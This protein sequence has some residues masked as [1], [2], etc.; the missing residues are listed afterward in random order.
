MKTGFEA[1]REVPAW[2][3]LLVVAAIAVLLSLVYKSNAVDV[4]KQALVTETLHKMEKIDNTLNDEVLR[5]RLALSS[6][7]DTLAKQFPRLRKLQSSLNEGPWSIRGQAGAIV[8]RELEAYAE[9]IDN[10]EDLIERF[11]A[12][13]SILR[14]STNF[15]PVGGAQLAAQLEREDNSEL[16]EPVQTLIRDLLEYNVLASNSARSAVEA[17][18]G[19]LQVQTKSFAEP[20]AVQFANLLTHASTILKEKPV[21][22]GLVNEIVNL[23]TSVTREELSRAY[24][25]FV[26]AQRSEARVY[27]WILT[28]CALL[29]LAGLVYVVYR[30]QTTSYRINQANS[31]YAKAND[32][33][34]LRTNQLRTALNT[35]KTSQTQLIQS[36]K[37]SSL[38]QMVA[39][40][41][42]EINTPLGYVTSNVGIVSNHVTRLGELA[43]KYKNVFQLLQMPESNASEIARELSEVSRLSGQVDADDLSQEAVK[44]LEDSNY[45]LQ[46]ISAIVRNLRD[47]SRLDRDPVEN[48]SVNDGLE[49]SLMIAR[50]LLKDKVEI[51]KD[52]GDVPD[53][54]CSPS[55]INQV[56][57]NLITNSVQAIEGSGQLRLQTR[58]NEGRVEVIFQDN[59]EGIPENV[60]KKIFDPFFTTKKVGEGTGLGLSIVYRIV[61]QHGGKIAV[62]S[63]PGKGTRFTI[64]LPVERPGVEGD[65]VKSIDPEAAE[66]AAKLASV[67]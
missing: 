32:S 23:D 31:A 39:G 24:S 10:K 65:V 25:S 47:F 13:N 28:A 55:Q 59:G 11:K 12:H 67:K 37:M 52:Y 54:R 51:I 46:Q 57:L 66:S 49:S 60:I 42:H 44:L 48:Y 27:R 63:V 14:N 5:S 53:F 7:Y 15:V 19:T 36:E 18:V 61:K 2:M 1:L 8:D 4:E 3:I 6:D 45:G 50:N 43:R 16:V 20:L 33:L 62:S 22:D 21:T 64:S 34:K 40:V 38:G 9:L 58:V 30:L 26:V 41:S 56:F 17:R 35:I 29:M